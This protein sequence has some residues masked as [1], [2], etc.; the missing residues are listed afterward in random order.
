MQQLKIIEEFIKRNK[1]NIKVIG[2]KTVRE[3]NGIAL[4]SR[5]FLL[6]F[7]EKL[8]ASKIY[9]LISSKKNKLIKKKIQLKKIKK[10][11]LKLGANEIDYIKIIDVNKL[12]KPYIKK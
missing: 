4:S 5:N 9:R 11:I 1:I 8:I 2:C 7:N 12:I 6:T 3:K 10:I